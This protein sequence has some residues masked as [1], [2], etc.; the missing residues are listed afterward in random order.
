M[1]VEGGSEK[2]K[3][4]RIQVALSIQFRNLEDFQEFV[5]AD[6]T[7]LSRG[8]VFIKTDMPR[9]V[10]TMV[11]MQ[12]PLPD[13][14]HVQLRGM[15]RHIKYLAGVPGNP[16]LGMGIEFADL[17]EDEQVFLQSL[18]EKHTY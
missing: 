18:L 15:V 16:P 2:R 3:F 9:Q 17:S 11:L 10:G 8:G 12:I 14:S 13:G 5:Q 1:V 7:D 6:I 4:A